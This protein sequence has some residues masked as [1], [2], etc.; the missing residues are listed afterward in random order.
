MHALILAVVSVSPER[1]RGEL[2]TQVI[3]CSLSVRQ[4]CRYKRDGAAGQL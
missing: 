3:P 2:C 1:L 4:C